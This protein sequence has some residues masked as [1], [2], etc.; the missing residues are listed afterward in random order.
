MLKDAFLVVACTDD[1]ELN[2]RIAADTREIGALVNVADDPD[3]C[4][5]FFPAVARSG[6]VVIAVGTG[7]SAPAL[8]VKIRDQL[9]GKLPEDLGAFADLL[10]D[11]RGEIKRR[12]PSRPGRARI[13]MQLADRTTL[14]LFRTAG[15]AGVRELA[16]RLIEQ[17]LTDEKPCE[18]SASE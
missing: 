17:A 18:S 5:F 15:Q 12:V 14:D 16:E 13:N 3:Q 9:A 11:L 8:A 2:A 4:D 6:P 7:G 10:T 1:R